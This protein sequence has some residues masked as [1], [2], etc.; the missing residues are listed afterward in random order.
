M[1]ENFTHYYFLISCPSD[2]ENDINIVFEIINDINR[3]VG[4]ENGIYIVPLFWKRDAIP[5][6]GDSAQNIIN[7][8]LLD[9]ADGVIAL[10]WTKFGT[11]TDTYG[12]GTEEEIVKA[13]SEN[14]DV[15]L[16][17][18]KKVIAPQ[19]INYEQ[20]SKV[21]TF[22]QN[23]NGLFTSYCTDD[24]LKE[25]LR[26]IL[27]KLIFKYNKYCKNDIV[28]NNDMIKFSL[29]E[30]FELGWFLSRSNFEIPMDISSAIQ[31]KELFKDRMSILLTL[32]EHYSLLDDERYH[33]VVEY[34]KEVQDIGLKGYIGKY[35]KDKFNTIQEILILYKI[36]LEKKLTK[37]Q[38]AAFQIGVILGHY[39]LSIQVQWINGHNIHILNDIIQTQEDKLE[40]IRERI[41]TFLKCIDVEICKNF[42]IKW[43]RCHD[44]KNI[45][46]ETFNEKTGILVEDIVNS[47]KIYS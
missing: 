13:I 16:L 2:V 42:E 8:Q 47:L 9:E 18:S 37:K 43:V 28:C 35:G 6:A 40:I 11:P 20:L 17:Y 36:S 21:E 44:D 12:S 25:Q 29:A 7:H 31:E 15:V 27:T 41:F 39:L 46:I 4:E 19:Q 30:Y 22:K 24:D 32:I 3:S 5:A 33:L 34:G 26:R 38:F 45:D 10:F 1:K 23:Y 14:K